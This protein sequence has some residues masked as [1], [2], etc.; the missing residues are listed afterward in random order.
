MM[1]SFAACAIVAG[2]LGA[3]STAD[4]AIATAP[5]AGSNG[6][7]ELVADGCGA[8]WYRGPGGACHRFG[9]GPGPVWSGPRFYCGSHRAWVQGP[10]GGWHWRWLPNC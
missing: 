8:G 4:A 1:K 10:Y 9:H 7:I 5:F 6:A 2:L 3:A